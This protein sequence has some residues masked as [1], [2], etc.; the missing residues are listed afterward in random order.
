MDNITRLDKEYSPSICIIIAVF[1]GAKTIQ[2]CIDSIADQSYPNK[3]L[4]IIDGGSTDGTVDIIKN[5]REVIAYWVSEP[6]RGIAHAWNKGL[7]QTKSDWILFLGVDDQLHDTNVLSDIATLLSCDSESDLV[8][9]QIVF[10]DGPYVNNILGSPFKRHIH[11]R[12]MMIPHTGC[13]QRYSLFEELGKFDESFKVAMDYE[14]FLRK[15]SIKARFVLRLIT[16]MGGSGMSTQQTKST[17][18][19]GLLAQ[20]K[21]H[22]DLKIKIEMWHALYQIR[23]VINKGLFRKRMNCG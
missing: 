14:F 5:N 13:F 3:K 1:N 15:P 12:R 17:L 16:T 19:E 2:R 10:G 8:Y 18:K 11:K 23:H 22:V 9:G 6:D 7:A 4:I 21:N 20:I